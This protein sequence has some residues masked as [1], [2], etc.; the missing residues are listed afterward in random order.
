M[1][2]TQTVTLNWDPATPATSMKTLSLD[3]VHTTIG[4]EGTITATV[5]ADDPPGTD[6]IVGSAPSATS[7]A[8]T[9]SRPTFAIG[10][11]TVGNCEV[12]S[13]T[14]IGIMVTI[15]RLGTNREDVGIPLTIESSGSGATSSIDA[16]TQPVGGVSSGTGA[17][18]DA[19]CHHLKDG[20]PGGDVVTATID[21]SDAV[22]IPSTATVNT[23]TGTSTDE[24]TVPAAP[25]PGV[26]LLS[27]VDVDSDNVDFT[28]QLDDDNRPAAATDIEVTVRLSGDGITGVTGG[29]TPTVT[30]NWDPAT[31]ATSHEDSQPGSCPYNHRH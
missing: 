27:T 22:R 20:Y 12:S 25:A 13:T 14:D 26:S 10:D 4:T 11:V 29:I 30:I 7:V 18:V 19:V 8:L 3:R 23:D 28:V 17:T 2:I 31:P 6:Y 16:Y 21:A 9:D 1:G 5:Q 24:V 15:T